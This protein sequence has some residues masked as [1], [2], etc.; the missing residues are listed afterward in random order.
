MKQNLTKQVEIMINCNLPE[1]LQRSS[2]STALYR[3]LCGLLLNGA[4]KFS[5]TGISKYKIYQ[6]VKGKNGFLD[7]I[8]ID[9]FGGMKVAFSVDGA[10]RKRSLLKLKS[11]DSARKIFVYYGNPEKLKKFLANND[12]EEEICIINLGH[13]RGMIK[14]KKKSKSRMPLLLT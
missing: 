10:L 4:S 7:I 2:D 6:Y 1:F 9:E 13:V 11:L 5:Y 14:Q 3:S 8:W 12:V